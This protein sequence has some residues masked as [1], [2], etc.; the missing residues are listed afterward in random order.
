MYE[1]DNKKRMENPCEEGI[2]QTGRAV[3]SIGFSCHLHSILGGWW[4][5]DHPA[6]DVF[7]LRRGSWKEP[8]PCLYALFLRVAVCSPPSGGPG[9]AEVRDSSRLHGSPEKNRQ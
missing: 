3:F 5:V 8:L 2:S 7:A 1:F 6:Y 4:S 9:P